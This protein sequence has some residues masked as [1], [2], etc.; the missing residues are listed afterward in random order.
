MN[1]HIVDVSLEN[2]Q[3]VLIE[4]SKVRP[5][6]VDFWADW[7]EPCKNLMPILEK[8]ANEYAGA[9]L[10]AKVNADEMQQIAGQFGVQSLPTVM[11]MQNG[12]PVD[13]FQ[14]AQPE[15]E[16]RNFLAKYLPKPWDALLENVGGLIEAEQWA[17]ALDPLRQAYDMSGQDVAI[18]K[19]L[20]RVLLEL[21][22]AD[23]AQ[24]LLA[25]IKLADQDAQYEQLLALMELKQNAA[26][27]PEVEALEQQ[28][29]AQPGDVDLQ[30][31]LAVQ[32]S[33]HN[34][35][36]EALELL[37][38]MLRK[39]VNCKEGEVKK[40]A[41]DIIAALGKADPLAIKFQRQVFSLLY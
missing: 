15:V 10:L 7:C 5:V 9:F 30:L 20:I 1:E 12:Q 36:Q 3:Q 28:L 33:Q 24:A 19:T 41:L 34:H 17:E 39:D 11:L 2:A 27:A 8:L 38:T 37:L 6:L 21:N 14:G 22:R 26:K 23:D 35:S 32:Y 4:E 29:A 40:T 16:I 25:T 13:G 31:Q 18:A